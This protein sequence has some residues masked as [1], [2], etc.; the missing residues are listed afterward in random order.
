VE[1]FGYYAGAGFLPEL[2][3]YSNLSWGTGSAHLSAARAAGLHAVVDVGAVFRLT[4]P[5]PPPASDVS[6]KWTALADQLRP[7]LAALAALYPVDEPYLYGELNG[8]APAEMQRRLEEA[9]VLI[10]STPGFEQ[11]RLA[12]IFSDRCL[13][14]MEA[15]Q[16]GMPAGV[17]WVGWDHYAAETDTS[18]DRMRTFM[19]FLRPDQ[20]LVVLP[21][22]ALPHDEKYPFALERRVSFWLEWI[23]TH[24]QVV[25]V[26]PFIYQSVTGFTGARELPGIRARY[27]QIGSC[28]LQ[29]NG[30]APVTAQSSP[31]G[32]PAAP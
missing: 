23:E 20:R 32:P 21:D 19:S 22:A 7:D 10:R 24:P 29:A 6:A 9:A 4:D 18:E 17:D 26:T 5:T 16:A 15:G 12:T 8:V 2:A 1:W 31:G 3:G 11:V 30:A 27:E 13:E 28:I 25:A 14:L